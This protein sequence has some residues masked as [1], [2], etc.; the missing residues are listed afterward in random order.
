MCGVQ[1]VGLLKKSTIQLDGSTKLIVSQVFQLLSAHHKKTSKKTAH[2]SSSA[3]HHGSHG[4]HG[5]K[6][7]EGKSAKGHHSKK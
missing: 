5:H 6:H 4:S 3:G 1:W 2:A 7:T